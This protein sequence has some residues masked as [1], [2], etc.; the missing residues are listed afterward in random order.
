[1]TS[2]KSAGLSTLEWQ[3]SSRCNNGSCVEIAR[4]PDGGVAMRDSKNQSGPVLEFTVTEFQSFI[5][6]IKDGELAL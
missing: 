2:S 4:L 5:H 6:S 3:I 1:M